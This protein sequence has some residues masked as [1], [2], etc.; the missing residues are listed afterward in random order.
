[1]AQKN[2]LRS[3]LVGLGFKIDDQEW[4]RF[5]LYWKKISDRFVALST[6]A[7]VASL[8]VAAAVT[9][10]ADELTNLYYVSQRTSTSVGGIQ[11][12]TFG[13]KQIGL[14]AEQATQA[15]EG[16]AGAMRLQPGTRGLLSGLGINPNEPDRIKMLMQLIDVLRRMPYYQGSAIASMFGIDEQTFFMLSKNFDQ[17]KRAMDQRKAMA[18]AFGLDPQ[19]IAEQSRQFHNDVEKIKERF[20]V[21]GMVLARDFLP[22]MEWAVKL[23]DRMLQY[24][25]PLDQKTHG[26][27]TRIIAVATALLSVNRALA[28]GRW[29]LRALGIGGRAGVATGAAGEEAGAAFAGGGLAT[30]G[31]VA[32]ALSLLY[33][34]FNRGAADWIRKKLGMPEHVGMKELKEG[35]AWGEAE[36]K[37][38]GSWIAEGFLAIV[39]DVRKWWGGVA[40]QAAQAVTPVV[41]ATVAQVNKMTG[42][43]AGLVATGLT[44]LLA[45]AEGFRDK[46]YWDKKGW[47]I[48]FGHQI[49]PGE[50]LTQIS[51]TQGLA[52]L[53]QD[54]ARYMSHVSSVV[55]AKL[56]Q[57]QRFSLTDLAYNI[58]TAAFD[59]STLLRKLNSG[60]LQGAAAEFARWNKVRGPGGTF[61]VDKG[62][63]ARRSMEERM[64]RSGVSVTQKT[65]I[66]VDGASDPH[67]VGREVARQQGKVN[68]GIVRNL[69]GVVDSPG[70]NSR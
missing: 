45:K 11:A 17:M 2:I 40:Q 35:G 15:L 54:A 30:A 60:D 13:A 55:M 39:K 51:R 6:Q 25:G 38:L 1:M 12:F 59:K 10:I 61:L 4:K 42:G 63:T 22:A 66:H 8:E 67:S 70:A 62:L 18:Q 14:T 37:K 3:Y 52:L 56:T 53:A 16:L 34:I 58:G 44:N 19:K 47:S 24:L 5:D 41:T 27:S 33:V 29:V 43:V 26:W 32:A 7:T 9:H 69:A 68:S 31:L 64:F 48:G 28:T 57:A 65:D 20:E 49:R 46:P 21:L 36:A 50:N 23:F